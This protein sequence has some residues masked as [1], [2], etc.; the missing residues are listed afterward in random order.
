MAAMD[1]I[2]LFGDS[3][4]E[5]SLDQSFGFSFQAG[6]QNAYIRRLDVINRGYSGYN[7]TLCLKVLPYLIAPP[8][9]GRIRIF[10]IF[11]GANDARLP[12]TGSP[13][14]HIDKDQYKKNLSQILDDENLRQHAPKFVLITPPP[15][16][17]AMCIE[18]DVKKGF[19]REKRRTAETTAAYAQVVRDL[20]RERGV[21]VV[22]LWTALMRH[23]GWDGDSSK[24][25]PGSDQLPPNPVLRRLLHDGL[26]FN[27]EVYE[28]LYKEWIKTVS[29]AYPELAPAALPE[30]FPNWKDD[31]AWATFSGPKRI[32]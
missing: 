18:T 25:L 14:Q 28:I 13:G 16:E 6:I 32:L 23:A 2:V 29:A 24:P 26:H 3:L 17:E 15:I 5:F 1:Q 19:N 4:T 22:D 12:N 11:L 20:G 7:T 8:S 21:A 31:E 9:C 27:G 30:V 10:S